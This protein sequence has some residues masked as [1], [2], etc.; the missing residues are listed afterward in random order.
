MKLLNLRKKLSDIGL[1]LLEDGKGWLVTNNGTAKTLSEKKFKSLDAV[2]MWFESP[3]RRLTEL[4]SDEYD[5]EWEKFCIEE[6]K[7]W[8]K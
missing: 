5:V 1:L 6:N 7:E 8:R 3:A 2:K 4:E